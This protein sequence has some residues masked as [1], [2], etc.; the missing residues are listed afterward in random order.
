LNTCAFTKG[1]KDAK[2]KALDI[3]MQTYEELVQSK[4]INDFDE[5][6][7]ATTM[8]AVTNLCSNPEERV[9]HLKRIFED[10]CK[11]GMVGK[12][13]LK[14]LRYAI[15]SDERRQSVLGHNLM[16]PLDSQWTRNIR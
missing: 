4:H 12:M 6:S 13:V 10:C 5:L 14:E 2:Q 9:G 8:K 7:F 11:H 3:A 16:T 15:H 1:K